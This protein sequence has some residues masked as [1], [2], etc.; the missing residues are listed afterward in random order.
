MSATE[1]PGVT[2]RNSQRTCSHCHGQKTPHFVLKAG[3]EIVWRQCKKCG[4]GYGNTLFDP[5]PTPKIIPYVI[6][7]GSATI[8]LR[9]EIPNTPEGKTWL[10]D[11]VAIHIAASGEFIGR[12]HRIQPG[13]A[14]RMM[15]G[16]FEPRFKKF[17][18]AVFAYKNS[19]D[20]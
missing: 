7:P 14:A 4:C 10:H 12:I 13:E 11:L 2:R 9:I 5:A 20:S 18:Q 8:E 19:Q 15:C 1:K 6:I 16:E 17:E 3:G